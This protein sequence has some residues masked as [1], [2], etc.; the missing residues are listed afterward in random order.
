MSEIS[1]HNQT[2]IEKLV[3]LFNCIIYKRDAAN[4]IRQNQLLIDQTIPSD[5]ISVV[6]RLVKDNIPIEELKKGINK[7][8]NVV[9]NSIANYPYSEPEADSYLD[10]CIKNNR[11]LDIRLNAIRPVIKQLNKNPDDKILQQ[12]LAELFNDV[13]IYD[14]YYIIKEN[15]LFPI[16]ENQWEEF[17]CLK[18]MWSFHDD[19]RR[20]IKKVIQI[21]SESSYDIK[22]VN[23]LT[24]DIFFNMYAL[25]FREERIMFPFIQET[26]PNEKLD[27]LFK[28][29]FEIGFPYYNPEKIIE[30]K[31]IFQKKDT[32]SINLKSG[33]LN[34]E[35]IILLFNH[36]P[37]DI[38]FVDENNKV[39]YFSTPKKRIFHR[40]NIIIGR[41]VSNCHPPESVHV[42]EQ[43][44]QAFRSGE[45][46]NANFWIK[47]KG[48]YI[49]IQYFA[50]RNEKGNYK[51]VIEVSQEISGIQNITGE[52]RLLEWGN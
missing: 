38:T 22:T 27:S 1:N 10:Y 39:K 47:M 18:V 42:V 30:E 16:L 52:R 37:V 12:K 5:I 26:I 9:H 29:S 20:N 34:A 8:I 13:L 23:S 7:F 33:E 31:S 40:T 11:E 28:E 45:Q 15:I 17:R 25:I 51:G 14:K 2:R 6:D 21:L 44:I 36:L 35:Q 3:D 46:D 49:L 50:L 48:E 41:D 24:G 43:I 19:I 32:D 4:K